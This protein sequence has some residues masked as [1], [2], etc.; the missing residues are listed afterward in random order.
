[1]ICTD[2][3][4]ILAIILFTSACFDVH[5]SWIPLVSGDKSL[6]QL[7]ILLCECLILNGSLTD[8]TTGYHY[9]D[10]P[11]AITG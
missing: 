5:F 10:L 11:D 6:Q 8:T 1:M 9:K 3:A 7:Y 2:Q 4:F